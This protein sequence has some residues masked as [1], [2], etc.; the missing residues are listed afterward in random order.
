MDT[1]NVISGCGTLSHARQGICL[2]HDGKLKAVDFDEETVLAEDIAKFDGYFFLTEDGAIGCIDGGSTLLL[3][4]LTS[5]EEANESFKE[6][7]KAYAHLP[8]LKRK[9]F[10]MQF[11]EKYD[12]PISK[13]KSILSHWNDTVF[14]PRSNVREFSELRFDGETALK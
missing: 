6:L 3:S 4:N 9:D 5:I 11:S 8:E 10:E 7:S 12:I 13:A 14:N 2:D 1:T